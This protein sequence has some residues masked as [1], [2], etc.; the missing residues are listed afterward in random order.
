LIS[1]RIVGRERRPAVR[2]EAIDRLQERERGDLQHVLALAAARVAAREL[3][4][5]RQVA[6]DERGAER[7]IAI[8]AIVA[9]ERVRVARLRGGA[10][11]SQRSGAMA[12]RL[13]AR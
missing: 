5:Q 2:I 3:A 4:G 7:G 12:A 10:T 13:L 11:R 1:P 8:P 9:E 6:L